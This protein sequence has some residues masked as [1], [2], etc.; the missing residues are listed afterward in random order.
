[1]SV[2]NRPLSPHLQVYRWQLTMVL[3]ILHRATGTVLSVGFLLLVCWLV[4]ALSG[5]DAY[6]QMVNLLSGWPG[7]LFLVGV[8]FCFFYHLANG[9]RHLAWDIGWGF[10]ISR[11]Y[12]SGWSVIILSVVFTNAF[13]W[14]VLA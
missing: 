6:H 3:S 14:L 13:W 12:A 1:M 8:S 10:E 11:V 4:A 2:E 9:I 7:H 5:A